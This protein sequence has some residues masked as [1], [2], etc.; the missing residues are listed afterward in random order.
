LLTEQD[1]RLAHYFALFWG[2]GLL[3]GHLATSGAKYDVTFL[4]GDHNFLQMQRN[5]VLV[6]LSF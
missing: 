1:N 6:L 3:L 2:L 5:F 4:L